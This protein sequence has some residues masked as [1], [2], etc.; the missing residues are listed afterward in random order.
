MEGK[1]FSRL[2]GGFFISDV[3]HEMD[4]WGC[5]PPGAAGHTKG[6]LFTR[7]LLYFNFKSWC[8]LYRGSGIP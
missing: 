4:G 5:A 6:T 1:V 7:G 8:D 3:N 2:E